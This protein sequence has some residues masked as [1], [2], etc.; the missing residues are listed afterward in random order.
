M[1]RQ[2]KAPFGWYGGKF[3]RLA[4]LKRLLP[5]HRVYVETFGG[6]AHLLFSKER[7]PVEVY[8]DIDAALVSV[9]RAFQDPK[10]FPHLLRFAVMTPH[11]REEFYRTRETYRQ[12]CSDPLTLA[13]DSLV[14]INMGMVGIPIQTWGFALRAGRGMPHKVHQILSR[15]ERYFSVH[16][17]LQ[18]VIILQKD[19]RE[20]LQEWDS[21]DTFFFCDPPYIADTLRQIDDIYMHLMTND[22]HKDLVSLLLGLKG[23]AVLAGYQHPIYEPLEQNGWR[24]I[25]LFVPCF[26]APR[27]RELGLQGKYTV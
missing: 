26:G 16:Q 23:A 17:R 25:D 27:T 7:S 3:Y 15:W 13:Q 14:A 2:I 4:L 10:Q 18:G 21:P 22:D 20:V 8:N 19:F 1:G 5:P 12:G 11:S 6:A 9:F 24:R